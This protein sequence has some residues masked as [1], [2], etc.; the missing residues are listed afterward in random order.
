[1][2]SFSKAGVGLN[3]NEERM[4]GFKNLILANESIDYVSLSDSFVSWSSYLSTSSII[5]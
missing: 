1:M 2:L 3:E 5:W 4:Y